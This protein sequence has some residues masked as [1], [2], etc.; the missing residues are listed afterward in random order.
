MR[1]T[2]LFTL[3]TYPIWFA[4]AYFLYAG[5]QGTIDTEKDIQRA[6]RRV[7]SQLKVIRIAET[8]YLEQRGRYTDDWDSLRLF[9]RT[10]EI[11]RIQKNEQIIQRPEDEAWKGDS[12]LVTYDTL[13]TENAIT[14][15][16]PKNKYPKFNADSIE[17]IP[18]KGD[19]KF[20]IFADTTSKGTLIVNLIEV[21]DKYPTDRTR[22]ENHDNPKRR[23][24]RFGSRE[25]ATTAGNWDE[26]WD[27]LEE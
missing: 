20:E 8:A 26:K 27:K 9:L 21:V 13:G 1:K 14:A 12:V 10:G 15:L 16:F 3:L 2:K 11:Y 22:K 4:L 24:L 19:K 7:A 5:V 23:F 6:E 18:N 17:Y 25:D